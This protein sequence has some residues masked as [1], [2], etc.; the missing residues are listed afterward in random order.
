M[1]APA[2][3][4]RCRCRA[5]HGALPIDVKQAG[6][7]A[8]S[9]SAHKWLLGPEGCAVFHIDRDFMADVEP[10]EFGWT[11]T[12]GFEDYCRDRV[13]RADAGRYECGT[14]NSV[15]L[16]RHEGFPSNF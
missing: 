4:F 13:L 11:N 8:L 14:L 9:A 2:V 12:Q 3:P 16:R 7:H 6:I 15:R 10:M 5:G 1:Q